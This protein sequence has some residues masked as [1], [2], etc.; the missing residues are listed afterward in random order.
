MARPFIAAFR[1]A[2]PGHSEADIQW[3]Y[4]FSSGAMAHSIANV[5]RLARLSGGVCRADDVAEQVA[6]M[7]GFLV[8]GFLA[9][10]DR[11]DAEFVPAR[12]A[13]GD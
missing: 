4:H 3:A 13:V 9:A 6:R 10:A 1:R 7:R 11:G 5:G 2:L 12:A 8:A